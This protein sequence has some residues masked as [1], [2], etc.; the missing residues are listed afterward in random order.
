MLNLTYPSCEF[1]IFT[2]KIWERK[3]IE[4]SKELRICVNNL[5]VKIDYSWLSSGLS[6]LLDIIWYI[7]TGYHDDS[8]PHWRPAIFL[9]IE[10]ADFHVCLIPLSVTFSV[11]YLHC[12]MTKQP[13]LDYSYLPSPI[14][15][16]R[17][18]KLSFA[19]NFH[20]LRRTTTSTHV[21]RIIF[22]WNE[23]YLCSSF[24]FMVGKTIRL[25]LY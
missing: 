21:W 13:W 2:F 5:S 20:Q 12:D 14:S 1:F 11:T 10:F 16:T 18:Q 19:N 15:R 23:G 8:R 17:L 24:S 25:W 9:C 6:F 3:N 7:Y 22:L 4:V